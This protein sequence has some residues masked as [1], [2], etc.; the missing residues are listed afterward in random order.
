[1]LRF[2]DAAADDPDVL[3]IKMT[4]YRVGADSP[5]VA[6]LARAAEN[7][8]QVAVLVELK[9]RFDEENNIQWARSLE[10]AGVHVAYG[11]EGLKTHAK[12]AL[13]VRR[14]GAAMRRYVHVGTGN[15]NR[16]TARVYTDVG[17]FTSRAD[18][19]HDASELFNFLTGFSKKT[20]Y[21]RLSV[22]PFALHDRVIALI[23][24][25]AEKAR[26]GKPAGIVAKLN[27]LVDASVIRALYRASQA[28][29]PID[30]SVRG[31]CCL[32]PGVSGVSEG[33][34]V[35]SVVGRFLE[36]SRVF[37]FG[38]GEEEEIFISSADWMPRNFYR[39]VELMAP[40]QDEKA[41]EKIR[42]EILEPIRSDNCR[43]RDLQSDGTYVRR[44]P[45]AGES[46]VDTQG[47][48]LDRLAR[49]G[50]KAVP[51]L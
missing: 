34:R 42:Q 41:R 43:A 44:R 27:S 8:K 50:L 22:A 26:A 31:I 5:V 45:A 51:T 7:G 38:V 6:A 46:P 24:R 4:L 28:G 29:V 25:E 18:F 14:E 32:R 30:L 21:K 3:A 23:D 37:S 47:L 40:I 13:V 33:I 11:V 39:R 1:M 19:G 35:S 20:R 12:I 16:L 10:R 2:L 17:L 15:Y 9:A 49:R 48:L 36:H